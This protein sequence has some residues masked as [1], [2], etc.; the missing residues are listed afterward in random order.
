MRKLALEITV[1]ALGDDAPEVQHLHHLPEQGF[2]IAVAVGQREPLERTLVRA[3]EQGA[4]HFWTAKQRANI[5]VARELV[6]LRVSNDCDTDILGLT[7]RIIE[8]ARTPVIFIIDELGKNLEYAAQNHGA[9]DLYLLQKLAEVN[10]IN[11]DQTSY[12]V[13]ILGLLHQSFS[14]YGYRLAQVQRNEWN[15]IQGRF[16]EIPFT[17]STE[18]P[19]NLM[20][21]VI[22]PTAAYQRIS[23]QVALQSS[24]WSDKLPLISLNLIQR[25]YPLHPLTAL[26]LPQL[27]TRYAQN[28]RSLFTFLTS[29]EPFSFRQFLQQ[30]IDL[31]TV[32]P[33]LK[34]YWLYDYFVESFG[35][36]M[37]SRPNMQRWLEIYEM[38][39]EARYLD[40]DL[41]KALKTIGILNLAGS[42]SFK[43]SP[44]WVA[45]ALCDSPAEKGQLEYW[46]AIIQQLQDKGLVTYRRTLNE[47]RLWKGSDFDIEKEIAQRLEK[48]VSFTQLLRDVYPLQ[49]IVAQRHS[50][51]TGTLR[52]FEQRYLDSTDDLNNLSVQPQVD[53]LLGYWIDSSL[54][55]A[56]V[57]ATTKEGKPFVLVRLKCLDPLKTYLQEYVALRQ[58]QH[59]P[60]LSSDGVARTE[61]RHRLIQ[62]RQL[63]DQAITQAF[64]VT[65]ATCW[66][67]GEE[68]AISSFRE[69][70]SKLSDLC[71]Q[72]YSKGL[73]VRNELINR[74]ELTT[75]GAT[76]RAKLLAAMLENAATPRL[77]LK[78]HGPEVSMYESL[79]SV[80]G[81]HREVD[82]C[83]GFYPPLSESVLPVWQA[84]ET[85]CLEAQTS[86]RTLD[87][88]YVQLLSPPYGVKQGPIP[89]LLAAVFLYHAD[90]VSVYKDGTFIPVLGVEHFELLVKDPAR[91]AVKHFAIFGLRAQIFKELSTILRAKDSNIKGLRNKTVLSIVKPLFQFV[92][93]LPVCTKKTKRL[94]QQAQQVLRALLEAREPDELL[95]N[96][97]PQALGLPSIRTSSEEDSATARIFCQQLVRTLHEIQT[98]YDNLLS[99]GQQLLHAAFG[100]HSE[101]GKLRED[102][103]VRAGYLSSAVLE[104]QLKSFVL[105]AIDEHKPDREWLEALLM[106]VADKPVESWSDEDA[107]TFEVK[108]S[109][110][111]RRFL[112]LE[113]LHAEVRVNQ[114]EGLTA[115]RVT[116]TYPD[117]YEAHRVVW[118]DAA[119]EATVRPIIEQLLQQYQDPQLQ[120]VLATQLAEM[121]F[122]KATD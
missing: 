27:C 86:L 51:L 49:P 48:S 114:K 83:W 43:A 29:E 72:F 95:F 102:L 42:S 36:G 113:A 19:I 89:V 45:L 105:A 79:L 12:P 24:H 15:K 93:R 67:Q 62:I 34:L 47:L 57:P 8:K 4:N 6:D 64:D 88:L 18:Q 69:F 16:E 26:V 35:S 58:I 115:R 101:T 90:D 104:R 13:Y 17:E 92:K 30:E 14:D 96:T 39:H 107:T 41:L 98:Y 31:Q 2:F 66:M 122:S 25:L 87:Q 70:N 55:P 61:V 110:L 82:G 28:D 5:D 118:T 65:R 21:Q 91:F 20:T 59:L 120:Q 74:R 116:I 112:D 99:Q 53:G 103:R 73:Q 106:I 9:I 121:V 100:I 37:A 77:G 63:L 60:E 56:A 85:F 23:S 94:S 7:K 97:L 3:L 10:S 111:A 117:G 76:A 22:Q 75:Q 109:D 46:Q 81:I 54:A 119:T 80:T 38:I 71:D 50:Y 84:I 33:T 32:L 1:S 108:L 78:G 44:E 52:Y 40:D 11:V 68:T